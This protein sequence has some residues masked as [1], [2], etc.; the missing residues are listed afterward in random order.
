MLKR[1]LWLLAVLFALPAAASVDLRG[2]V[3][4]YQLANGMKWLIVERPQAPVFTGYVRLKVGGMDEEPGYTGLAHLFEHMAFKGTPVL[5][6]SD[7]EKEKK[8]LDR[9]AQVGD[10]LARL[11]RA[12]QA[13][14]PEAQAL[15][16]QLETLSS[17]HDTLA[18]ENALSTLFQL[19]GAT[20]LNATTN[21]D[22]TS[23]F[24]S[25]PKNRLELWALV[26]ASR[27]VSPVLRDF[28][29]ERDVVLEERRMRTDSEPGGAM[30]EE[31]N[32][33]AFTMSPYR[34][35]TVGYTEDLESMTVAKAHEFHQRYY[36][37]SNAVGAVVGDVKYNDVVQVLERTFGALP[38]VPPPPRPLFSEPPP[39]NGRRST[40]YFDANPRL[41]MGFRKPSLPSKD[42]YVFDVLEVLLG[43]GRTGRL[44]RRLVLKDRLAQGV[45]AFGGPGSRLDNM[46]NV[47]A[48]PLAHAKLDVIEK[49][50]WEELDKLKTEK[51]PERELEKVRNR[52]TADQA[53]NLDSNDGLASSLTFFEAV[54]G[55]WRYVADHPQQIA[56]VTAEDIQRVAQKYFTRTNGVVVDL[57]KPETPPA[58]P[59]S[60]AKRAERTEVVR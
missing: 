18:D 43:Q 41:Y 48:I 45:G 11:K 12:G 54:A 31:L 44:H 37:A 30:Y 29:K 47:A 32:Q 35:P 2:L 5:G 28:Y 49:A 34:W 23:Y 60:A 19:N 40:V 16:R 13:S 25:L 58:A 56:A 4:E 17:E 15:E 21:K 53:R 38:K 55:D 9:I 57:Q 7:F 6:T 51:V 26:E 20:N 10:T 59:P 14:T 39:R 46:F 36:V 24:V 1:S 3:K 8:L 33:L 22:L 42:D 50:I 27:L 52:L